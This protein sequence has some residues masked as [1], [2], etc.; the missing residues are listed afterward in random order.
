MIRF[1]EPNIFLYLI[2]PN[3]LNA[4][5]KSDITK[6]VVPTVVNNIFLDVKDCSDKRFSEKQ[7]I[8]IIIK[9]YIEI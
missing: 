6:R 4:R 9:I 2:F 1:I 8:D 3:L 5:N 7:Y